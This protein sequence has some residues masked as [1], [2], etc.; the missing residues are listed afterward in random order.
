MVHLC[1]VIQHTLFS[2]Q[3]SLTNLQ[4]HFDASK[5]KNPAPNGWL[6]QAFYVPL[7]LIVWIKSSNQSSG[8]NPKHTSH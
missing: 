2:L 3:D 5:K 1:L 7:Q 6:V 8:F 4:E